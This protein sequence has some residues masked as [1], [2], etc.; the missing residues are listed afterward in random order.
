LTDNRVERRLAAVLA[1]DVAGYSSLMGHDEE[2]TLAQLKSFRK[3]LVDPAISEHRGRIVKTTGD[4]MLA[5]FASAVDAA[6]CAIEVQR[7][8][9]EQN[10]GV[11]QELRIEFRIG[12]HLGDIIIDDNDI[13]GDGVNIAA[14]LEGLAEPGGISISDDA[15]RQVRGKVDIAFEDM[16]AQTLKNIPEPMRVWRIRVNNVVT[17][18]M[19]MYPSGGNVEP[20]PREKCSIAVL[21][22]QNLS[23]DPEQ[24]YFTDGVVDDI[25]TAL[26]RF[27]YWFVIARNS[28]FTYKGRAVDIK[29]VGRELGVRYVLEGGVRKAAGK[30]RITCQLVDAATGLNL[31]ADRFEGDLT[32]IFVLQDEVAVK[33]IS[34]VGPKVTRTEIEWAAQQA[35]RNLSAYDLHL[36]GVQHYFTGTPAGVAEALRLFYLALE[37]DPR[38]GRAAVM[39]GSCIIL[40]I[41]T[42]HS[43]DAKSEAQEAKRLLQLALSIDEHDAD[44]LALG[45]HITA[46]AGD[47]DTAIE[48]VDRSI[49]LN[50]NSAAA[51]RLRGWTYQYVG[52]AEEAVRSFERSIPLSPLDPMLYSTFTGMALAFIRLQRFDEAVVVA[53]KA[54]RKNQTYSPIYRCLAAALAHL[55]RDAEAKEALVRLLE[56]EPDLR[57][58]GVAAKGGLRWPR[59]LVEGLHK[60]GLPE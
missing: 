1:A 46:W 11:P 15:Y 33:V 48:M 32:D 16:G 49:A 2:G 22:F 35:P 54:L 18:A 13:F 43:V 23:G 27:R 19:P 5:E 6:R 29:K 56:L 25:I 26:S 20:H 42:G 3:S 36:R 41:G 52:Q 31:W 9:A 21:P 39:A 51:W 10:T 53:E 40:N 38:Y 58:S 7:G 12:I 28:S 30:V 60:A 44:T 24:D 37:L 47:F 14:R 50:P 45:G 34:A 57:I 59:L 8:M 55:G 17:S 4:G